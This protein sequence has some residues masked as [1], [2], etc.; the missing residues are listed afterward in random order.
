MVASHAGGGPGARRVDDGLR[1]PRRPDRVQ[2]PP[3]RHVRTAGQLRAEPGPHLRRLRDAAAPPQLRPDPLRPVGRDELRAAERPRRRIGRLLPGRYVLRAATDGRRV[4][5][6][7]PPAGGRERAGFHALR[8]PPGGTCRPRVTWHLRGRDLP[9][10]RRPASG[11]LRGGVGARARATDRVP[12]APLRGADPDVAGALSVGAVARR[13]G[14]GHEA[15]RNLL[16]TRAGPPCGA[17]RAGRRLPAAAGAGCAPSSRARRRRA[18]RRGGDRASR[19]RVPDGR[20]AGPRQRDGHG[21][22]ARGRP[23]GLHRLNARGSLN[24]SCDSQGPAAGQVGGA[25]AF[26]ATNRPGRSTLTD[27]PKSVQYRRPPLVRTAPRL[28]C[29]A[30]SSVKAIPPPLATTFA[31]RP[32][33]TRARVTGPRACVRSL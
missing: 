4:A 1:P 3:A 28:P 23:A 16:R 13:A 20:G 10:S 15:P 25:G 18:L 2:A 26:V 27:P 7:P 24:A 31:I 12:A 32:N 17:P 30:S 6:P 11:R 14:G 33:F 21:R 22:A 29:C 8:G 9:R 19:R 5:R